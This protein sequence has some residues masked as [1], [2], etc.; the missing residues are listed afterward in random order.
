MLRLTG[1][2]KYQSQLSKMLQETTAAAEQKH[3]VAGS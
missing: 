3:L 2:K 1:I